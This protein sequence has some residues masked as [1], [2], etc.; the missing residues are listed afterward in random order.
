MAA[1]FCLERNAV[2]R[3]FIDKQE[4]GPVPPEV[5]S[6]AQVLNLVETTHLSPDTVI[7]QV[8]IDGLPVVPVDQATPWPESLGS[9]EKIEVFTGTLREIAVDSI[10]EAVGYLDRVEYALP[11]LASSF[12]STASLYE[13]ENLKQFYEG[14]YWVNLLMD[15]LEKSFQTPLESL[16]VSGGT[17]REQHIK[18]GSVLKGIIEAHEQKDFGLVADLL[19]FEI[20]PLVPT[21]KNVFEAMHAR[22]IG[23][24]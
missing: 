12:R 14:F 15:R 20:A 6:L 10:S 24:D 23:A 16:S 2:T 5:K 17:A 9:C 4:I 3:L 22:I 11:M 19:E 21:C 18:L 7:R 13:L 8:H 1:W